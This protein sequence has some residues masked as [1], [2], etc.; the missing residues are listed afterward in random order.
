MRS[1][2]I[3]WLVFAAVWCVM[4]ASMVWAQIQLTQTQYM[5]KIVGRNGFEIGIKTNTGVAVIASLDPKRE[6]AGVRVPPDKIAAPQVEVV[7]TINAEDLAKGMY[8][9]F[10][11][12]VIGTTRRTTVEPVREVQV[13]TPDAST[14]FG[15]LSKGLGGAEE[16]EKAGEATEYTVVG[17]ITGVRRNT[18]TVEFPSGKT[19]GSV[20][21]A[22]ADEAQ[23][24]VKVNQLFTPIG[25][26]ITV[27]GLQV[28]GQAQQPIKVLA[29]N[30]QVQLPPPGPPRSRVAKGPATKDGGPNA[31][32]PFAPADA[33]DAGEAEAAP[34]KKV[35]VPGK[36][37]KVN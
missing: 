17:L 29:T 22:V 24:D 7:G 3:R 33:G 6:I 12:K 18:I 11:A 13:F 21:A 15:L 19:K 35:T 1:W 20:A 37:L 10:T 26:D 5:G 32:D 2:T 31:A 36:I 4:P 9:R 23:V 16:G 28:L 14:P 27:A 8:V 34:K 25:A 30:V